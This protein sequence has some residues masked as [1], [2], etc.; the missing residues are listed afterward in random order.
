MKEEELLAKLKPIQDELKGVWEKLV[1]LK[2]NKESNEQ[3]K[4]FL[5]SSARQIVQEWK[6]PLEMWRQ[7]KYAKKE[8]M[9]PPSTWIETSDEMRRNHYAK[10]AKSSSALDS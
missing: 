5:Y 2:K 8:S 6:G 3:K 10:S 7:H 9:H 1:E 4:Y